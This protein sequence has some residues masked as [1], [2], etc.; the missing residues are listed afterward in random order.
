MS[1]KYKHSKKREAILEL[2]RS[3]DTHPTAQWVY[4]QLKPV[5]PDLSLATVYRNLNLFKKEG[6]ALSVGVV[7]GEERFD[8]NYAPHPHLVCEKCNRVIDLPTVIADGTNI[9]VG[10]MTIW[11]DH[12]KTVYYGYCDLCV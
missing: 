2:I 7:A 4:G 5:I 9:S 10:D 6:L 3:T 8:G 11:I 1:A 12:K